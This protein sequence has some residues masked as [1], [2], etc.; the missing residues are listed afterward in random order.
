MKLFVD[1][2]SGPA[3]LNS[4]S[5]RRVVWLPF[6]IFLTYANKMICYDYDMIYTI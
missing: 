1:F 3:R 4:R 2:Y 5:G 6:A